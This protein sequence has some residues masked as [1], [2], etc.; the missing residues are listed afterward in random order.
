LGYALLFGVPFVAMPLA[1]LMTAPD[2]VG[3]SPFSVEMLPDIAATQPMPFAAGQEPMEWAGLAVRLA[4]PWAHLFWS[5]FLL[6]GILVISIHAW[7]V[8]QIV[9]KPGPAAETLQPVPAA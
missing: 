1:V 3:A 7:R 2:S 6:A 9:R 8:L 5:A 4:F